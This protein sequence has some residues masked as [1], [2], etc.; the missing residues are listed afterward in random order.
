MEK[1]GIIAAMHPEFEL[2][3][4]KL[5]ATCEYKICGIDFYEGTIGN[6]NIILCECGV[7]K[8]NSA[9]AATILI[10]EFDCKLLV[11]TGI[12]GGV[13][14]KTKDVVI[15]SKLKYHDFDTTIFGYEYGQVPSMP[16]EY[17]PSMSIIVLL[18]Q[19]LNRLNIDYICCPIYTG[20]QFV[21][22]LNQLKKVN[23]EMPCACE[24]EGASIAQV[25]VRSGVDF[26]VLRYISDC[27]GQENQIDDY[28]SFEKEMAQRSSEICLQIM[29]NIN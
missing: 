16:K 24:M 22:D 8:V 28:L 15:G 18:K 3:L 21:S 12:A 1:I 19:I 26:I 25:A 13:G 17:V 4:N 29:N 11:N 2:L 5:E 23:Y 9:M 7:G 10:H 14:L 27:I 6:S 20:D